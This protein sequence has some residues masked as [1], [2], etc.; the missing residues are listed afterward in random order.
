MRDLSSHLLLL[1]GEL[2]TVAIGIR[3]SGVVR[4]RR[5]EQICDGVLRDGLAKSRAQVFIS[6]LLDCFSPPD[7]GVPLFPFLKWSRS[8][9]ELFEEIVVLSIMSLC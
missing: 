8:M 7:V 6:C 3:K 1:E 2:E 5:E 9:E 4:R